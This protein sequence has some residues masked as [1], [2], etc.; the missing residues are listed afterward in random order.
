MDLC[1][2][3]VSRYQSDRILPLCRSGEIEDV[4][5]NPLGNHEN[6]VP[7]GVAKEQLEINTEF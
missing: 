2:C 5:N 3:K 4:Y 7:K 6:I 1:S